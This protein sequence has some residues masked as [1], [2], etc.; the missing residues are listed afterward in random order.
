MK[1]KQKHTT[2]QTKCID[3]CICPYCGHKFD[4]AEALNYDMYI[5]SIM[6]PECE[7]FM[8]VSISVEYMCTEIE[9]E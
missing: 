9:N 4:G 7:K 1:T 8:E 5:S 2:K 3:D 6:C